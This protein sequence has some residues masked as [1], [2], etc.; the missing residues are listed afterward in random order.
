MKV[1]LKSKEN[2]KAVF[3]IE[4]GTEEFKEAIQ[5]A[6]QQ[7]KHMFNIPGFRKGKAPRQVIESNYGKDVF[8]EDAV[9]VVLGDKYEPALKELELE[10]IDYPKVDILDEISTEKP[11]NVEFTVELRPVAEL[12]NYKDI[13]IDITKPEV[14]EEMVNAEIDK[15]RESNSRLVN[16][17]DRASEDGDTLNIDFEGFVDDEPFEGGKAEAYDLVLGSKTF[18]PGFE[19]QLI[20]VKPEDEV[21]VKVTFPEDYHE[22]LKDKDAVF[23]VV[24]NSIKRKELPELDDDFAM[25]VSEFDTLDE[26]KNNLR[27]KLEEANEQH[28][29]QSKINKAVNALAEITEVEVPEVMVE[30]QIKKDFEDFTHRIAQMGIDIDTYY[31]IVQTDEESVKEELREP[32]KNRVKTDLAL[33]AFAKA[34]NV[35]VSDEEIDNELRELAKVY[36]EKDI[37]KFVS[38]YK[39]NND[40]YGITEFIRNRKTLDKLAE[41][42]EF[43]IVEEV[44]EEAE[45]VE[46]TVS[47]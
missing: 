24:V 7:N 21:E 3:T 30:D 15:E 26:Y 5:K 40:L 17:T 42:V 2:S 47:E 4:I 43:N 13:K 31:S 22:N 33:E 37:E 10:P 12:G 25:D 9:N 44:E 36:A 23:K 14:T 18:I 45:E 35:E 27:A 6:Y 38:D 19:E 32:A 16:I 20:G 8:Y 39:E 28:F 11:F 29:K 46:E 1:E 34:E 41:I